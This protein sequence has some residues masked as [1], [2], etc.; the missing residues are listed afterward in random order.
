MG[1]KGKWWRDPKTGYHKW[2]LS[3]RRCNSH[4]A[5]WG[6]GFCTN[7]GQNGRA[8]KEQTGGQRRKDKPEED[9]EESDEDEEEGEEE[10]EKAGEQETHEEDQE[11][12]ERSDAAKQMNLQRLV[13]E[14]AESNRQYV[15]DQL[16]QLE[17]EQKLDEDKKNELERQRH[18][19]QQQ[20]QR[21]LGHESADPVLSIS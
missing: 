5:Y 15:D 17:R 12:R 10:D 3:C 6:R 9:E 21:P 14:E 16:Q 1:W 13:E 7:C 8:A 11:T 19:Q 20:P 18:Q 2:P 4:H